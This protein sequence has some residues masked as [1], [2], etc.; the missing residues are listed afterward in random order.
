M[1]RSEPG[2]SDASIT[3]MHSTSPEMMRFLLVKCIDYPRSPKGT[4]VIT[5]PP[6]LMIESLTLNWIITIY[7]SSYCS[8]SR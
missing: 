6:L 1:R 7:A 4:S 5:K 8:D 2:L 3:T